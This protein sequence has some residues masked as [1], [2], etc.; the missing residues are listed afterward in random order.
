MIR[1]STEYIFPVVV[2]FG[3]SL[4]KYISIES[5]RPLKLRHKFVSSEIQSRRFND[6]DTVSAIIQCK[7]T[8]IMDTIL[9]SVYTRWAV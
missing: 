6:R 5:C 7:S 9:V 1:L 8:S 4:Q 3:N 2:D